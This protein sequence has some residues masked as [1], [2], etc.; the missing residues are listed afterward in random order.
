LSLIQGTAIM[1]IFVIYLLMER[2][3]KSSSGQDVSDLNLQALGMK[4]E[5]N[6]QIRKYIG[7]KVEMLFGVISDL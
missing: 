4:K 1:L 6:R 3:P 7:V 5:I 2:G